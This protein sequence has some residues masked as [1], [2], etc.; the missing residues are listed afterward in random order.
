MAQI[1]ALAIMWAVFT[2]IL[3]TQ[4]SR[5]SLVVTHTLFPCS[6]LVST[7]SLFG[8]GA[9]ERIVVQNLRRAFAAGFLEIGRRYED[10]AAEF[11]DIMPTEGH[12]LRDIKPV[13]CYV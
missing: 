8:R 3:V 6:P 7:G 1:G 12:V 10:A 9:V 11:T 2:A 13:D 4:E 5:E